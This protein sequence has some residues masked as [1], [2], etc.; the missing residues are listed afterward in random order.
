MSSEIYKKLLAIQLSMKCG[1]SQYNSFGGFSY[2]SAEGILEALKPHLQAQG[3]VIGITDEVKM[4]GDRIYICVTVA[5]TDVETGE[6]VSSQGWAREPAEKRGMDASQ[7]SGACHSYG[8]KYALSSLCA[9]DDNKDAD[10]DEYGRQTGKEGPCKCSVCKSE[11]TEIT[12]RNGVVASAAE[13]AGYTKI[14][15]GKVLCQTC[16]Q[17]EIAKRKE[18][19]EAAMAAQAASAATPAS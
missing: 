18:A 13:Y 11:L 2:R 3:L 15:Y 4:V 8:L 19:R 6:S 7:L 17:K 9:L 1:K 5:L 10:T 12:L 16:T 14:T